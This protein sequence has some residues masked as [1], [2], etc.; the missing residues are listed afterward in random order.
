MR[1]WYPST[2]ANRRWRHSQAVWWVMRQ[3]SAQESSGTANSAS[4]MKDTQVDSGFLQFSRTVP[5]SEVNLA[6]QLGQRQRRTP[7][8]SRP[9]LHGDASPQAEHAGRGAV[10]VGGLGERADADLLPEPPFL[11]GSGKELE[12][13]GGQAADEPRVGV[14]SLHGGVFPSA[15]TP[16]RRECR[17]T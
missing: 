5:V 15:R 1:S 14:Q 11:D 3:A 9:S 6:P 13:A 16:T 10:A 8:G 17:Q 12:F 2:A 4:R 7:D